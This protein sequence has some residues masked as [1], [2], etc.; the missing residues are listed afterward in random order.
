MTTAIATI[1]MLFTVFMCLMMSLSRVEPVSVTA[2]WRETAA[3]ILAQ[4]T[5]QSEAGPLAIL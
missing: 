2:G 3:R 1:L 4:A 5:I